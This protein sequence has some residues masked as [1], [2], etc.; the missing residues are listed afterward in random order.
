MSSDVTLQPM[1][2]TL[3]GEARQVPA[4]LT[5]HQLLGELQ[6]PTDR[7]AVEL[8]RRIVNKRDWAATRLAPGAQLEIVQFVGGG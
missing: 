1:T 3:N 2:I 6:L 5:I 7:V 4:E 8:D